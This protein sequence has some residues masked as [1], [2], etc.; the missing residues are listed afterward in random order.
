MAQKGLSTMTRKEKILSY[1]NSKDYLPLRADELIAVLAVPPEDEE[2]FKNLLGEL[3]SEGRIIKTKNGHRGRF[4]PCTCGEIAVGTIA[5]SSRGYFA[6]LIPDDDSQKIYIEGKHLAGALHGDKASVSIDQTA[7][8]GKREGHVLK[9]LE[10]RTQKITGTIKREKDGKFEIR[11]DSPKIYATVTV[12]KEDMLGAESGERVLIEITGYSFDRISGKV[13]KRLGD[14]DEIKSHIEAV[15]FAEGIPTEFP[16]EVLKEAES[17][18]DA[19]SE[20]ELSDRLDLRSRLIFTIDGD[21]ARDFDDAVSIDI[22]ENKNYRL[23]VHIADVSHYVTPGSALDC[24][25]FSRGT[26]V[27]LPDRVIPMLPKKLSN[28]ICSLNPHVDRLTLSVFMEITPDGR[29]KSHKLAKSV[30]RSRERMTYN[31]VAALLSEPSTELLK[32]YEY[33]IPTLHEMEKLAA[34][35]RKR[36][37]E[38]G[39]IDFDFSEAHIVTD[40]SGYPQ[41]I[42]P[43]ERKVS[44]KIIEEF[45]LAANE[46]IAEYAFRAE[47]PFVFRV[48]EPPTFES[49]KE[50]QL[51]V[52]SFGLGIKE[53]FSP[54]KPIHPKALQQLLSAASGRPEEHMISV[55]ALRSLMKAE[56]RPENSGHFGLAAKYYCHFTSPIRRY[57][58]LAIHRIL[59]AFSSGGDVSEYCSF[60]ASA[61]R[62]SSETERAAQDAER[63]VCD[64]LKVCY[65]SQYIGYI[66]EAKISSITEFGIFAELENTVEGLIHV[67]SF[68]DDYYIFDAEH[69]TLTGKDSGKIYKIGDSLDIAVARC[70]LLSRQ[71]DFIPAENATMSDID[72]LQKHAY[73]CEREKQKQ[74]KN[75]AGTKPRKQ[76][77]GGKHHH[78]AKPRRRKRY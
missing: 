41:D 14:A 52:S 15:L 59:K 17:T 19:V 57:P 23:G 21:D 39:S 65:M 6:F 63:D 24:E 58:D 18:P 9:V 4:L 53:S 61:A 77:H 55:Y 48:H 74:I 62:R 7:P 38:R 22:L 20:S 72:A 11:P 51:F 67:A 78:R 8:D 54:D 32:K 13:I 75:A 46:T 40:D 1:I 43:V 47:I 30:I 27:Y 36:R 31:D 2:E 68:K 10:R 5:C 76:K 37:M 73:K 16:E 42:V 60:A 64:L 25:A 45:M 50:F 28:G 26:S 44:H 12:E 70:D 35:L 3:I 49:M 66:F 29:I 71:I 69:K 34:A 33:L 56:Y